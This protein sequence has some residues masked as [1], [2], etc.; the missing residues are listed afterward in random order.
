MMLDEAFVAHLRANGAVA[1][2]VGVRIYG[3]GLIDQGTAYPCLTIQQISGMDE[4]QS[5]NGRSGL[6]R[7]RWQITAWALRHCDAVL[8]ATHVVNA[9][10]AF[11]GVLGGAG[12]VRVGR[13]QRVA[14]RSLGRDPESKIFGH[15]V[16]F[17]VLASEQL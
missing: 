6:E 17:Y 7:S 15:A 5:H 2:D 9:L 1:L 16:D 14:R 10:D 3:A 13:C 8:A 12:G 4:H 11:A